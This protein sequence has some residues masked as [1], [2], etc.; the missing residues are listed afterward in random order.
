MG[1][2][3]AGGGTLEMQACGGELHHTFTSLPSL[4]AAARAEAVAP[5]P[6][7]FA[8]TVHSGSKGRRS[9]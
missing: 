5:P 6:F 3:T 4:A 7:P 1:G 8:V 9:P 2:R